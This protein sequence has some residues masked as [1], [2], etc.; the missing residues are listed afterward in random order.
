[1][2]QLVLA[3]WAFTTLILKVESNPTKIESIM[4]HL[5]KNTKLGEKIRLNLNWIHLHIGIET[6]YLQYK[7]KLVYIKDN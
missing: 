7:K 6:P 2:V 1:M 3:V 5:N 4:C